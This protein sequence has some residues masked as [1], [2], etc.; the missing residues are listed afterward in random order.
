MKKELLREAIEQLDDGL[1][2]EAFSGRRK[3]PVWRRFA[4]TGRVSGTCSRH[5][6]GVESI[7]SEEL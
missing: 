5:S 7:R 4:C 2:Q 3:K 1:I 6:R